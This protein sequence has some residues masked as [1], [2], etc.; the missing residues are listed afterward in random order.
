MERIHKVGLLPN[1]VNC[2]CCQFG[3]L[4][5]SQIAFPTLTVRVAVGDSIHVNHQAVVS[6]FTLIKKRILSYFYEINL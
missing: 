6:I 2:N 3:V 1:L 4:S 5:S